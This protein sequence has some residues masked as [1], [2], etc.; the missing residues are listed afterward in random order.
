MA[1][2][3]H[4]LVTASGTI[5]G[6]AGAVEIFSYGFAFGK[7]GT[8]TGGPAPL[9]TSPNATGGGSWT[10]LAERVQAF[11][12][13]ADTQINARAVLR[14]VKVAS[15]G[16]DGKY[17]EAPNAL[18]VATPGQVTGLTSRPP[19]IAL[20]V[21]LSGPPALKRV[22]GGF[23][24]PLPQLATGSDGFRITDGSRQSLMGSVVDLVEGINENFDESRVV[25]ASSRGF[26]ARVRELRVGD[27]FDTIRRRR[28]DLK[29]NYT[30]YDVPE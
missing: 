13:R 26:N 9:N 30:T 4:Y 25:I 16:P 22:R 7:A 20:R 27:V 17:V 5:E 12:A 10:D 3:Y 21:S 8:Q 18:M 14:M 23:Y 1:Y 28:N 11:H 24:L 19:Q 29:E 6:S 15:I 2:S